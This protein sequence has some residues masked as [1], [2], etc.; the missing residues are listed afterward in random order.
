VGYLVED[1]GVLLGKRHPLREL[2]YGFFHIIYQ[3]RDQV[4]PVGS[5]VLENPCTRQLEQ[6]YQLPIA[7]YVDT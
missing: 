2:P 3:T 7:L 4:R 5:R 6:S 1:L